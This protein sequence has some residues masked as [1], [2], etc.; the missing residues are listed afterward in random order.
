MLGNWATL[1]SQIVKPKLA[2]DNI[3]K[4]ME[5]SLNR[6]DSIEEGHLAE[7]S[8][9]GLLAYA[10][11]EEQVQLLERIPSNAMY[12]ENYALKGILKFRYD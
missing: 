8:W 2:G 10:L 3:W 1:A 4:R 7:R 9:A 6:G 5:V 12:K 11:T